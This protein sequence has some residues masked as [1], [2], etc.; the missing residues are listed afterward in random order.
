[1]SNEQ[2][3]Q[4]LTEEQALILAESVS[5][6]ESFKA[7]AAHSEVCRPCRRFVRTMRQVAGTLRAEQLPAVPE[8]LSARALDLINEPFPAPG[9]GS[10]P[11]KTMLARLIF[12]RPIPLMSVRSGGAAAARLFRFN[13][14]EESIDITVSESGPA[15]FNLR[16]VLLGVSVPVRAILSDGDHETEAALAADGSFAIDQVRKGKV[17]LRIEIDDR[18][19]T[20]DL[21]LT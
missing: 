10:E 1:M 9:S 11:R 18:E 4:H 16:A 6:P 12:E 2:S 15:S 14:D 17:R 7:L 3:S 20:L 5:V 13:T 19:I 8:Y 21:D